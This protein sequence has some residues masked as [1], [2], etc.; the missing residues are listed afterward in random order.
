MNSDSRKPTS[1]GDFETFSNLRMSYPFCEHP[2]DIECR[3]AS[4]AV[5]TELA[6]VPYNQAH[7]MGI[8][9]DLNRGLTCLDTSQVKGDKCLDYE[10]HK[11]YAC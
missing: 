2:V 10:I 11:I 3:V 8:T 4:D 9:C 6:G 5:P 1:V 7:Q